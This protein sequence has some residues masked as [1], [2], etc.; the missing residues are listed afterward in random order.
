MTV[1]IR[2]KPNVT[3]V[4]FSLALISLI[5]YKKIEQLSQYTIQRINLIEDHN[6][7]KKKTFNM[8]SIKRKIFVEKEVISVMIKS[9]KMKLRMKIKL[10]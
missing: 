8:I 9:I 3:T 6:K 4:I 10:I 2:C 5:C 1:Y 7:L